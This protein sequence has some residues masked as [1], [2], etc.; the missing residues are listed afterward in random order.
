MKSSVPSTPPT[1]KEIVE[2]TRRCAALVDERDT[3]IAKLDE[4]QWGLIQYHQALNFLL[5]VYQRVDLP[6]EKKKT[7][8]MMV[9][10]FVKKAQAGPPKKT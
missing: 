5:Q 9:D 3:L 1:V 7:T 6:D 2:F 10:A 8:I 4:V